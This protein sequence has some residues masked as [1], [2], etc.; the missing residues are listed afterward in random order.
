MNHGSPVIGWRVLVGVI[1][2]AVGSAQ[3]QTRRTGGPHPARY[4]GTAADA[5][6]ARASGEIVQ[7]RKFEGVGKQYQ[8]KTPEYRSTV[9]DGTKRPGDWAEIK[10]Q[11]DTFEDWIDEIVVQ[12]YVLTQDKE[13]GKAKSAYSFYKATVHC[14]NV[15]KGNGHLAA[16][17]LPPHAVKR[18]GLP[19]AI[20]VELSVGGKALPVKSDS[21]KGLKLPEEWWKDPQVLG[22]D[23]VTSREYLTLRSQSPFALAAIDDYEAER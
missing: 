22:S 9:T 21:E 12:F 16:V 11:F 10:L 8:V 15:E 5:R 6:P 19:V 20:A 1:L 13:K 18:Y 4:S 7:I 14:V 2:M 17:Y 3:A 23:N